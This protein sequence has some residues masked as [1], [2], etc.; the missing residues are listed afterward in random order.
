[1]AWLRRIFFL[2]IILVFYP[3]LYNLKANSQ[4]TR[5]YSEIL[6]GDTVNFYCITIGDTIIKTQNGA[7]VTEKKA[8]ETWELLWPDERERKIVMVINR[9]NMRLKKGQILAVPCDMVNKTFMDFSPFPIQI[10]TPTE[11]MLVFD[12][13]LLAWAAYDPTGNLVR[14]GPAAGGKDYCPDIGRSCR[15]KTG[16]FRI[17]RIKGPDYRSGRYPVGCSGSRCARMP[18]AMFFQDNYAFHAGDLP[19]Y[20][21]SHGCVRLFYSDAK[22]LNQEFVQIG[23]KVV[24]FPY[25]D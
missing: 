9:T 16:T 3:V 1:M 15:T 25:P 4:A 23:T 17:I 14:W 22:W 24:I 8:L 19:G 21:A 20:N 18:F 6:C 7:T 10:E 13:A 12:P 11:K 2:A 5:P